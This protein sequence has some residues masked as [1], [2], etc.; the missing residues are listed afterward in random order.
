[1]LETAPIPPSLSLGSGVI[2]DSSL[3][4]NVRL[5][6]AWQSQFTWETEPITHVELL[7]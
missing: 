3:V 5:V 4:H 7:T 1:L 2:K 6:H